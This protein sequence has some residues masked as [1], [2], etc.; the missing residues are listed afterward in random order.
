[1]RKAQIKIRKG[2][3]TALAVVFWLCVWQVAALIINNDILLSGPVSTAAALVRL[4][5]TAGFAGSIFYS[6]LRILSGFVAG[7]AIGIIAA[8]LKHK[9]M[10]IGTLI[11]PLMSML[12]S[13]PVASFVILVLIW[14][15]NGR[16]SFIISM[17]VVIPIMFYSADAGID[18]IDKRMTEMADVFRIPMWSRIKYIF[19]PEM[20]PSLLAGFKTAVGMSWKS[21]VAAE[22]IGQPLHSL[23]NELYNA[24]IYLA[25]D[26]VLAWTVVIVL[27][28]WIS[29]KIFLFLAE[30]L[31]PHMNTDR[32]TAVAHVEGEFDHRG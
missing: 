3:M 13:I 23:G 7:S 14:F 27:L 20:Y 2:A 15:G 32:K 18:G 12:K 16:L 22:V 1:M 9:S 11:A 31:F 19:L 8:V 17:L 5:H 28:S 25:T 26:E 29:E 6:L 10:I 21:G 24:K 4:T 30:H